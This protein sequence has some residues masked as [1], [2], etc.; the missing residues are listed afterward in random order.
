MKGM[1]EAAKKVNLSSSTACPALCKQTPA[2]IGS[3][4]VREAKVQHCSPSFPFSNA[5]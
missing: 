1:R 2:C 5:D 4:P 3:F